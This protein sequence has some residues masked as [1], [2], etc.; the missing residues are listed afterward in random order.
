MR[1]LVVP[2]LIAAQLTVLAL[3]T[4]PAAA[5]SALPATPDSRAGV[6]MMVICGVSVRMSLLQPSPWLGIA[7]MSCAAGLFNAMVEPD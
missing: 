4:P 3:A 6:V 2:L 5:S 1:R 7:A